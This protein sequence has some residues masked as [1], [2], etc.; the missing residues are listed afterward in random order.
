MYRITAR[1]FTV[2]AVAFAAVQSLSSVPASAAENWPGLRGPSFDGSVR[3]ASLFG[4]DSAE[5]TIGW[6]RALGSGYSVVAVDAE[7]AVTG[8]QAG[9]VDVIAAFD[10]ESGDELWRYTIGE[11]YKGYTGSHDGP[12]ATPTLAD[13]RVL[14]LGPR[15]HLFA[16][17][18]ANGQAL[19]EKNLVDDFG[20]EP[21]FYGFASSP[22]VADGVLIVEVGAGE[23]KTIAGLNPEDG[24]LMW[25]AGTDSIRYQS[26]IVATLGGQSQVVALGN[27]TVWGLA[28]ASGEVLWSYDHEGDQRDMGGNTIVPI[29]AGEDRVFLLNQHPSSVML[30]VTA[31]GEGFAVS[32]LWSGGSIK[33]TYVQPVYHDGHLYGMTG[34]IFTCVD[35]ATGETQWKSR[36]PGDGF[37]TLV[38][39]HLVISGKP[40]TLHVAKA[41]PERYQ[42]IARL[43]LFDQHSWTAPAFAGG[44]LYLRSMGELARVDLS[45]GGDAVA[46]ASGWLAGT[47]FGGFLA[48][49]E[50]IEEDD[51]GDAKQARVEAFLDQ[52]ESFPIIEDSGVVHFVHRSEATDV[53]II[54]DMIGFRREDPMMRVAGTDLFH[55]SMRFE[56]TAAVTYGF[57]ADFGEPIADPLNSR[58]GAGLFG[59]VSWF[60]MPGWEAPNFLGEIEGGGRLEEMQWESQV[61]EGQ[62]RTAQ[63]YLPAGYDEEAERRYPVLYFHGGGDALEAGAMKNGLDNLIGDSVAPVI[64][65]F[66]IADPENPSRDLGQVEP[67]TKMVVEELVPKIDET[68]RT[69]PEPMARAAVGAAGAGDVAL[70][71]AFNHPDLFA[72]VGTLWPIAFGFDLSQ[73][74]MADESPLVIYQTWGTY[75]IRSPHEAWDQADDNRA[76]WRQLRENGYRP[77]GGEVPEGFGWACWR[78]RTDDMLAAL[79]PLR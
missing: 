55:Y 32:E 8:F 62:T 36:E 24:Q 43:D 66:V 58:P 59:E 74:P 9:D 21:P 33:G 22:L 42:E 5:L 65:V 61:L 18:A 37:P 57:I 60:A 77:A 34:K 28:P 31:E 47:D 75:H 49:L 69:I 10:P 35:A 26:P 45:A 70:H 12:I 72:R 78:S 79:F 53:G 76:L 44:H 30:S 67:Y 27:K 52:Q 51:G 13:G 19:W 63:V 16:L 1:S 40:G 38:G 14:G 7:R 6:K 71:A 23:G 50:G 39:D 56:P 41:S 20:A 48:E 73:V 17:D 4:G 11:A 3:K 25:S 54:G 68:F 29:P 2:I 64:A 46:E 15:G